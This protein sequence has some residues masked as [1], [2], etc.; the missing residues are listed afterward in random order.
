MKVYIDADEAYPVYSIQAHVDPEDDDFQ[1]GV[2]CEL[3]Q[4]DIYFIKSAE[5]RY[6]EAQEILRS[7]YRKAEGKS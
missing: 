1:R 7:A 4:N 3:T 5:S 6:A 2:V